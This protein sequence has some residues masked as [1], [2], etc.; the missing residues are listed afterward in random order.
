MKAVEAE[1]SG[2]RGLAAGEVRSVF[3]PRVHGTHPLR[4]PMVA[5]WGAR[6]DTAPFGAFGG[7]TAGLW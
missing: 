6:T 5:A 2:P 1:S 3:W 7:D 4:A